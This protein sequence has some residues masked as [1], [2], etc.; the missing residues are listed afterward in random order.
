MKRRSISACFSA[1]AVMLT[2]AL[3]AV[4]AAAEESRQ[5]F[6]VGFDAEFPPYGYQNES[7]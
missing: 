4:T 1:A 6:T 3:S 5:T 7:C 2:A